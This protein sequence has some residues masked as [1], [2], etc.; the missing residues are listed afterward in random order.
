MEAKN[1]TK[2]LGIGVATAV[3]V[4]GGAYAAYAKFDLFKSPRMMYLEAEAKNMSKF[5]QKVDKLSKEYNEAVDASVNGVTSQDIEV[6]NLALDMTVPDPNVQK[7]L[8]IAKDSK[9]VIHSEADGKNEKGAGKIDFLINKSNVIGAEF[10]YDK[11]KL[12]FGVP[13]I[14]NKY[15]YYNFKDKAL[16]EQKFGTTG[17]PDRALGNQEYM[18]LLRIPSEELK[19]ILAEYA[20]LYAESIQDKQVTVKKG[21]TF[22]ADGVKTSGKELTVTFTPEEYKQ[23]MKKLTDKISKDDKLHELLYARYEKFIELAKQSAPDESITKLTKEEF[24]K[25]FVDFKTETDQSLDQADLGNGVKMVVFADGDDN[26]LRRTIMLGDQAKNESAV[27]TMDSYENKDGR[28]HTSFE[29]AGKDDAGEEFKLSLTSLMKEEGSKTDQDIIFSIKGKDNGAPMNVTFSVKGTATKNDKDKSTTGD[30]KVEI[31]MDMNDPTMPKKLTFNVKSTQKLNGEV[32]IPAFTASNSVN[33]ATV[34]DAD[35]MRI[36][37]EIEMG[38]QQFVMK[39]MQLFQEL[40]ILP[41][42]PTGQ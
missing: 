36:Q 42:M 16:V 33:L 21:A 20:K 19:P 35:L 7:A 26:I 8:D 12:G 1:K 37:Q 6:S 18:E 41:G 14:Y 10:F 4:A 15:G 5:S 3:L 31:S 25:E 32:K 22:E 2:V 17:L 29:L 30:A 34:A 11:E 9:I 13:A 40:G 23:L 38:S 28:E 27:I 39:N 24:K